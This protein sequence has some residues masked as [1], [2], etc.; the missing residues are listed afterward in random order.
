MKKTKVMI[1]GGSPNQPVKADGEDIEVVNTF[2]FLGSVIVERE[3]APKKFE[4]VWQWLGQLLL[5][6]QISGRT[7]ESP[8][9][10]RRV[11]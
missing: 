2:N 6:S 7:G 4:D 8:K 5:D 9:Q 1:Y 3:A 11:S 10:Q